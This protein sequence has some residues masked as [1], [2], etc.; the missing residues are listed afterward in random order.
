M[1]GVSFED[2]A[3]MT[4]DELTELAIES[5]PGMEYARVENG[6]TFTLQITRCVTLWRNEECYLAG[7][8]PRGTIDGFPPY[9]TPSSQG[10]P[11][12]EPPQGQA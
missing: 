2:A 7:D 3:L 10:L 5:N 4:D 12:G 1:R 8:P 11:D 6:L 9:A